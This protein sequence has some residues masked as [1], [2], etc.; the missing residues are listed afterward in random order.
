MGLSW[1]HVLGD[2]F[3]ALNF[4]TLWSKLMAGHVPPNSLHV[5]NPCKSDLPSSVLSEKPVSAKKA[6]SV[7][8]HWLATNH[9]NVQTHSFRLTPKQLDQITTSS[10]TTNSASY[11]EI[12]SAVVWKSLCRVR[13]DELSGLSAVTICTNGCK[14][15]EDE[16][17]SNG[18]VFSKVEADFAI[19]KSDVSELATLIAERKIVE[20]RAMERLVEGNEDKEDFVVYGANLTFVDLEEAEFY[21]VK[22]NGRK[23]VF[24]NCA[25]HG[26]GD[27][28]VVLVLPAPEED[29]DGED[30]GRS[31]RTIT[32][33]LPQNELEQLKHELEREWGNV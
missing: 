20:N 21:E 29:D 33:T 24:A 19:G 2:A 28:G 23:P 12:L 4:I 26:V 11:F 14:L 31:G 32:V 3:S 22:L 30:G 5:P 17:P 18:L 7:G 27:E 9:R 6:I 13:G 25:F 15:R 1:A 8:E 16:F 10:S